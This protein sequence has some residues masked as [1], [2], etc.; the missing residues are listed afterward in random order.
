MGDHELPRRVDGVGG[1]AKGD[2]VEAMPR[3]EGGV[4]SEREKVVEGQFRLR[5]QVR[6]AIGRESDVA[7]REGGDKVIFGSAYCTLC[8]E[9]TVI[10]RGGVLEREGDRAKKGSEFRRS[11]VIYF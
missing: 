3:R 9:R 1:E 8:R 6:P 2:A 7:R 5:E 11:F 10:L 4:R